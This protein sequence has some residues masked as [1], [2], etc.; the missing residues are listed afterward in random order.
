MWILMGALMVALIVALLS[1]A[2][3]EMYRGRPK[4]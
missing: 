4:K 2:I 3:L 1:W